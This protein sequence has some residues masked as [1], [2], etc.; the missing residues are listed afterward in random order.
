MNYSVRR[1]QITYLVL[2]LGN[3]LAA[4]FIWGINTIFLLDAGLSNFQAFAANAFFTLG[5][6][7]FEV[8]TGVVADVRGRQTSFML[9]AGSL[10]L[11]TLSYLLLWH[12][13]APF[14]AWAVISILIGLGFTF[15]SGALEAWVVD[16]MRA[17]GYKGGLE[18]VFARGQV[19]AGVAMLVGSVLGG[20]VAQ[21]TN[22]G[23]PYMIR[24]ALLALIFIV[25]LI[26]MKDYGFTP[27]KSRHPIR[28]IQKL[29]RKSTQYGLKN[30]PVRWLMLASIFDGAVGVYVF[31]AMQ[32]YLLELY[33][34]PQAYS[35]AG[36]AAAIVAGAQ[37]VGGI[38]APRIRSLFR[39]RTDAL[40][41]GTI[42][43]V[44]VLLLSGLAQSFWVVIILLVTWGLMFAAMM[45]I[46][47][48]YLND[49]IPSKQRATV[50]SFNSLMGS[51]GGAVSQ[52]ALGKVADLYGYAPSYLITAVIQAG[53]L[54]FILK[55]KQERTE[56]DVLETA[57]KA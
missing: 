27:Q 44:A 24:A 9:G 5:M 6:V 41:A 16:A 3:T 42:I 1:V 4:S 37:I 54:P 28:D 39:R 23:L 56:A 18:S 29:L 35:I 38:A 14:W 36:L 25:A 8:P 47:Q 53:A 7:L 49:L 15:F 20:L 2:L 51:S 21:L 45:P 11:S 57:S 12:I 26:Y 43:T 34:N 52:P 22:L 13:S 17:A 33:G 50:L 30:P 55:A 46:R 32:P 19:V 31:Y 10:V 40:L 48:A